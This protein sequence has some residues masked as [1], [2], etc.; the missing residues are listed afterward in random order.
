[1]VYCSKCGTQNPDNATRCSN[2]GAPLYTVGQNYPGSERQ[3]YR[4]MEGE[5]FGLPNGGMIVSLVIGLIIILIG[6]GLF[7]N[8]YGITVDLWPII[9]VI[10]GLL[11][12]IG[13]VYGRRRYQP[14]T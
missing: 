11:I 5:C 1:M 7:L 6:I 12:V 9:L 14:R 8:I 3:Y 2:C 13:A 10:V 4:H